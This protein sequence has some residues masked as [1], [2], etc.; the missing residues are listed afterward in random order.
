MYICIKDVWSFS[1]P[2]LIG[3]GRF[4]CFIHLIHLIHLFLR[5][6]FIEERRSKEAKAISY[7]VFL[8]CR[9]IFMM[10]RCID[11]YFVIAVDMGIW[12]VRCGVLLRYPDM[13]LSSPRRPDTRICRSLLFFCLETFCRLFLILLCMRPRYNCPTI[14]VIHDSLYYCKTSTCRQFFR[15]NE[16]ALCGHVSHIFYSSLIVLLH[17]A[18]TGTHLF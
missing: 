3:Y 17:L 4:S 11:V 16:I 12:W 10:Y 1:E 15:W 14:I 13:L 7:F 2:F 5:F 9:P 8:H 6:M 18:F